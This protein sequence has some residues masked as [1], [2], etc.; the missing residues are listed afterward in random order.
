[1]WGSDP[2]P[3]RHPAPSTMVHML[4]SVPWP[5]LATGIQLWTKQTS[6]AP[7]YGPE[8][9]TG[10]GDALEIVTNGQ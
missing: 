2:H 10:P 1:M 4:R 9:G 8:S 3:R 5:E 6:G 7:Q